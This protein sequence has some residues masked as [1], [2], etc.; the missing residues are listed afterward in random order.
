MD[1]KSTFTSEEQEFR[2]MADNYLKCFIDRCPQH[3]Q[4]LRWLVG[5]YANRE[6]PTLTMVNPLNPKMGAGQCEMYRERR[7]VMMKRGF[8]QMFHEMPG[9]MERNVRFQLIH[10]LGRKKYYQ[11]RKGERL[12]DPEAQQVIASICRSNGWNGPIVYDG[13]V[14]KMWW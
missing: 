10:R 3:E 8:T 1:S 9:Y 7:V 11:M 14:Q 5:R 6:R 4:C 13:E 2:K 12:I